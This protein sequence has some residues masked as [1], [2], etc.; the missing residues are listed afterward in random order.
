MLLILLCYNS[1]LDRTNI[2]DVIPHFSALVH[3]VLIRIVAL[4]LSC[5]LPAIE[6]AAPT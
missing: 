3:S 5:S 2:L 6:E 4:T 1:D